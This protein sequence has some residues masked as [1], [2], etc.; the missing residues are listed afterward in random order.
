MPAEIVNLL[1]RRPATDGA[2]Y[3]CEICQSEIVAAVRFDHFPS[4]LTCRWFCKADRQRAF[5]GRRPEARA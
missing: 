2:V 5:R 4:C 1:D 3:V